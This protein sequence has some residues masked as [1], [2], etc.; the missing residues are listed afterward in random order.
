MKPWTAIYLY[1]IIQTEPSSI[2]AFFDYEVK[3]WKQ[4]H[5]EL[6]TI[7]ERRVAAWAGTIT[8]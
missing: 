4:H 3:I 5:L 2:F 1:L 8:E 6:C 7:V